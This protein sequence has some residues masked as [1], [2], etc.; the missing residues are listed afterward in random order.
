M[1]MSDVCQS[2]LEGLS[3]AAWCLPCSAADLARLRAGAH[4]KPWARLLPQGGFTA[5]LPP[6]AAAVDFYDVQGRAA[7]EVG[8]LFVRSST[9]LQQSIGLT[10]PGS[11][12][13]LCTSCYVLQCKVIA[14]CIK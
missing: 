14:Q 5:A 12:C 6:S 13:R 9:L 4:G 1:L 11:H 2:H 10:L 8:S 7:L 3:C